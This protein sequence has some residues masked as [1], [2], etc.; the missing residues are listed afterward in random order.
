MLFLLLT[1]NVYTVA[2][3]QVPLPVFTFP[4]VTIIPPM[5]HPHSFVD[6]ANS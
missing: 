5:R 6:G 3:G 2:V 4:P 1:L